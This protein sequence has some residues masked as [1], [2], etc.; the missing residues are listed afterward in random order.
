MGQCEAGNGASAMMDDD[1]F[2]ITLFRASQAEGDVT[3]PEG[4]CPPVF[5][6]KGFHD[7]L[8]PTSGRMG[9]GRPAV[10]N[11]CHSDARLTGPIPAE[12][13][14]LEK[15]GEKRFIGRSWHFSLH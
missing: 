14:E 9:E 2:R 7:S 5:G 8:T 1:R 13:D 15:A 3:L 11:V 6:G 10:E 12:N 4:H